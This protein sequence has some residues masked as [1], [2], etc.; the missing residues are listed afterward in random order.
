[1][2]MNQVKEKK[3][4]F[5][6]ILK[7]KKYEFCTKISFNLWLSCEWIWW[8]QLWIHWKGNWLRWECCDSLKAYKTYQRIKN[9]SPK[10]IIIK[11][12]TK[13]RPLEW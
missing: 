13:S 8:E 4:D 12:K 10:I 5:C 7:L 3:F 9:A 1:M 2:L 6:L 11:I